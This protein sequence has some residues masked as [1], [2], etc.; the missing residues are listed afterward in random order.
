MNSLL[1][2]LLIFQLSPWGAER[3][4]HNLGVQAPRKRRRYII[5]L[6]TQVYSMCKK[7]LLTH[8]ENVTPEKKEISIC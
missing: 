2:L 3:P 7:C 4:E 1:F 6:D 8:Q 5:L